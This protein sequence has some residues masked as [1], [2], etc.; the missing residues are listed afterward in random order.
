MTR[1]AVDQGSLNTGKEAWLISSARQGNQDA[2]NTLVLRYQDRVYNLAARILGDEDLADDITQ[3]TFITA[4]LNL[5]RFRNGSFQGW[6]YRIATNACYDEFRKHK[7]NPVQSLEAGEFEEIG[8]SPI[9]NMSP[10]NVLPETELD[11]HELEQ[12]IQ[13]ALDQLDPDQRT[14]IVLVDQLE[15]DYQEA[16]QIIGVPIGTIKSRLARARTRLRQLL[17]SDHREMI[18]TRYLQDKVSVE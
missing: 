15:L 12:F 7:R 8:L 14:V 6:L 17:Y 18:S 3:N 16:A 11:R 1:Y 10:A 4:Y 5:P 2:F 13:H 9:S